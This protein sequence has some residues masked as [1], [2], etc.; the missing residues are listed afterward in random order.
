MKIS[1]RNHLTGEVV[2]VKKD[3]VAAVVKLK[4]DAPAEITAL[5]TAEA[6]EEMGIK[7]GDKARAVVKATEVMISKD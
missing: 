2:S 1:A 5:I 4:I 7:E 6:V 3:G